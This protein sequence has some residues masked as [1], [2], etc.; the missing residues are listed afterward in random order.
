[1]NEED[2]DLS[3]LPPCINNLLKFYENKDGSHW[4]RII[5]FLASFFMCSGLKE[6]KTLGII[7]Q[8]NNKQPYHENEEEIEIQRIVSRIY[9]NKINVP[10]CKK[11]KSE[12][13]GFPYFGLAELKLCKPDSKCNKCIN[14]IIRYKRGLE[15]E[16]KIEEATGIFLDKRELAKRFLK[17]Q[18]LFYDSGRL[19]WIWKQNQRKWEIIDETDVL[20][21]IEKSSRA[22]TINSTEKNEIIEA[23]KQEGRKTSP[24]PLKESWIQFQNIIYDIK[25]GEKFEVTPDYFV[26]NPIPYKIHDGNYE[27]TPV[28]D[29]IF[30]EWVGKDHVRTLYEIIAYCLLPDYPIQRLFCFVGAGMNGK[31][32]FLNLL[33]KFIGPE[34][35][36][37][38]ELD[39][40]LSSRFEIT[41]LHKKLVCLMGET[42]FK[43]LKKTSIIKRLTGGDTIGFEYKNK[44]PF[45]DRNYAKILIATNN[46]PTTTDKTIGFYR[47]WL[48]IDFPNQFSEQKDIL[49]DIPEEEYES[50]AL[51]CCSI[52]H[53]L[54]KTRKF[55]NEG[56]VEDRMKRFE[57]KSNPFDKFIKEFCDLEDPNGYIW[58]YDFEKKFNQWCKESRFREF[59]EKTIGE[60][61]KE[62]KIEQK[63][64]R[65]EWLNDGK[66]GWL[67]TWIGIKWKQ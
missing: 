33:K 57:E 14:P 20:N 65:A 42:N 8:W 51:K 9:K 21:S 16:D 7:L 50:L 48:I 6:E 46:L 59:S 55:T 24:K 62:C 41:K 32:C 30:E 19:W 52:L 12:T 27:Q 67:R 40:L 47:R 18:P 29:R 37:S 58:K 11:I 17:I 45:D 61:M 60:K 36:C 53:T 38:T 3:K 56:S 54:L 35:I 23:L 4:F 28:M 13:G 5:Q 22:D 49:L 26:V 34:N 31:S 63:Q 10:N 1:M 64:M 44:T 2:F 39:T 25:S 66:D 15:D 43:E